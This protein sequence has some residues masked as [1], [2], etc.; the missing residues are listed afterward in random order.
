MFPLQLVGWFWEIVAEMGQPQR[1]QLLQFSTGGGYLA[2]AGMR[3]LPVPA[4]MRQPFQLG[5]QLGRESHSSN[6]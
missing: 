2:G 1:R 5:L 3:S 4:G 6:S